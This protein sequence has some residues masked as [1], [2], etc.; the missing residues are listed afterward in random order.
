[1]KQFIIISL[2]FVSATAFSQATSDT[3]IVADQ[4][5]HITPLKIDNSQIERIDHIEKSLSAFYTYNR[6]SHTLI[7]V[8]SIISAA[9][10][11]LSYDNPYSVAAVIPIAG[12]VISLTGTIIYLDSYKFLNFKPKRKKFTEMT[13]Y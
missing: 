11:L 1:M 7:I 10:I 8:G 3:L 12:S 6:R 13:Y 2:L 4:I 5:K 9:G